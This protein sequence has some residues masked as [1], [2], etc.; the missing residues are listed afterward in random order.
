MQRNQKT[1]DGIT[2]IGGSAFHVCRTSSFWKP[3]TLSLDHTTH[4]RSKAEPDFY[5]HDVDEE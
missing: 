2:V 1:N 5:H 4:L 3:C